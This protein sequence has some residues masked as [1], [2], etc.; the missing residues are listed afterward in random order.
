MA[1]LRERRA[2]RDG[3]RL[4]RSQRKQEREQANE[5]LGSQQRPTV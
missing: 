1:N 4:Q 3:R 5:S 2:A